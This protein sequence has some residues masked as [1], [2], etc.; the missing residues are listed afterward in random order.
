[1]FH[2]E[3]FT[4]TSANTK[5]MRIRALQPYHERGAIKFPGEQLELLTGHWTELAYQML[6]FPRAPHDDIVDS[7][8]Y[9]VNIYRKGMQDAPPEELPYSSAAWFEREQYKKT[10]RVRARLPRWS[11]PPIPQLAFS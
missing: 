3:E 2:I 11:R 1:L 10:L 5:E 6:Q 4:G 9:H 7:L 8:A